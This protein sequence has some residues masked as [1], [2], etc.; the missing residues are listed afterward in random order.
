MNDKK[1]LVYFVM[2]AVFAS[3]LFLMFRTTTQNFR[4]LSASLSPE[5]EKNVIIDAS[6]KFVNDNIDKYYGENEITIKDLINSEYLTEE[7]LNDI[8]SGLY[9]SN[10]RIFFDVDDNKLVDIYLK[11]EPFNKLFKCDD[12]CYYDNNNYIYFDNTLYRVLKSDK[13]GNVYIVD[14]ETKTVNKSDIEVL[15]K[16]KYNTLNKNIVDNVSI[17]STNDANNEMLKLE[18]NVFVNTSSGYKL[19][20]IDTKELN[21]SITKADIMYVIKIINTASYEMGDGSKFN[22]YIISE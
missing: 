3:A 7:Q 5:E 8:T 10:T 11:S 6:K 22:P 20:N 19:Y 16:N 18:K 4:H 12:I 9:D 13:E 2:V 17:L 21:D 15:I 14:N 1:S